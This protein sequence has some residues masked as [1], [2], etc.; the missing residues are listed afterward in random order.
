MVPSPIGIRRVIVVVLDGLRPDAISRFDLAH[1]NRLRQGGAST[2][3]G[4]SV[5]PSVTAAAMTSLFT[6][7]SP[8]MHGVE[9]DRFHLPSPRRQLQ[10]MTKIVAGAGLPTSA[11]LAEMPF[12]FRGLARRFATVAGVDDATFSGNGAP[13]ILLAARHALNTQRRG[14]LFFHWPD[15][16]RAGHAHGWMS[17]PYA[18]AARRL[19]AALGLLTALC[20]IGRDPGTLL[21]ALADHGG[22]G[23]KLNDH[24]SPHPLDRTIPIVL[25]G[26]GVSPGELAPLTS[27]LDVPPTV[28][29]ALGLPIPASWSGRPLLEAFA[30]MEVAA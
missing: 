12:L 1:L 18:E 16:D 4:S 17:A 30:P 27:L 19:D 20:E 29:W 6:G 25:A 8:R 13:E 15:A 11:F 21:I 14:L 10:P 23:A 28:L 7:V 2:L 9:S 24:D 5:S 26:G 3:D 22:G